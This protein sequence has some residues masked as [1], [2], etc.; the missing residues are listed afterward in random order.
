MGSVFEE[1]PPPVW[2][3]LSPDQKYQRR[4]HFAITINWFALA[5]TIVH[6]LIL[7]YF[8]TYFAV[9][10]SFHYL[11]WWWLFHLA[12]AFI[13]LRKKWEDSILWVAI[14][15]GFGGVLTQ[16][17]ASAR[18]Y[19]W[20]AVSL[21][22]T[23]AATSGVLVYVLSIV[24]K[25]STS[26]KFMG[27]LGLGLILGFF[28]QYALFGFTLTVEK[29]A[30]EKKAAEKPLHYFPHLISA[31][32]C[33]KRGF[34]L[35]MEKGKWSVPPGFTLST[36]HEINI[37]SCGFNKTMALIPQHESLRIKNLEDHYLNAK[38]YTLEN[39]RWKAIS[40][41]PLLVGATKEI[42]W[43]FMADKEIV[44]IA[45]DSDPNKGILVLIKDLS[46]WE[47]WLANPQWKMVLVD[48]LGVEAR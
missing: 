11:D 12:F 21:W 9:S 7:P 2:L 8:I 10:R 13:L 34:T 47:R 23:S 26:L 36:I 45:S 27:Q 18:E 48:R 46:S 39:K 29:Q 14:F 5:Y 43:E 24:K 33:G 6:K 25:P 3:Q 28:V 20:H 15:F 35:K 19:N 16:G 22:I 17:I 32:E 1:L 42:P 30:I 40:N 38:I 37:Q 41:I 31:N 44:M 4:H